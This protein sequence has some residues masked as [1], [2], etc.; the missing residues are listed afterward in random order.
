[1]RGGW[2]FYWRKVGAR[3]EVSD[4]DVL[5]AIPLMTSYI[6]G[7]LNV[8]DT[9]ILPMIKYR[10]VCQ[11]KAVYSVIGKHT[12]KQQEVDFLGD[13]CVA[14]EV[15]DGIQGAYNILTIKTAIITLVPRER[16]PR[17]FAQQCGDWGVFVLG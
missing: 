16:H 13:D 3:K 9:C 11:D 7:S 14:V 10:V 5:T 8:E 17:P 12:Q 4:H 2:T 6:C 1:M 15:D